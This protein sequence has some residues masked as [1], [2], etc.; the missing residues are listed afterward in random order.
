VSTAVACLRHPASHAIIVYLLIYYSVP[1]AAAGVRHPAGHAIIVQ[2]F[3]YLS[4]SAC[5]RSMREASCG[6]MMPANIVIY[7]FIYL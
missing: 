2:I 1:A 3:I 7:L 6:S 5:S 4:F